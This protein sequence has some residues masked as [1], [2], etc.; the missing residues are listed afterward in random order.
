MSKRRIL[1]VDDQAEIRR[2]VRWALQ[3][4]DYAIYEATNGEL[5]LRI[6]Q[7]ARPELVVLD[8]QMPGPLDGLAV[9]AA[10]RQ[11]AQLADALL[12]MLTGHAEASDRQAALDAGVNYFLAKPFAPGRLREIVELM[13]RA[14]PPPTL[15]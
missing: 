6:A 9:C 5:A 11:D 2:L 8:Q 14:S 15:Q 13:L 7:V 4:G 12:L 1:I 3:D 10:F